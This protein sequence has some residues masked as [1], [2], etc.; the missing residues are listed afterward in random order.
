MKQTKFSLHL[1]INIRNIL[2]VGVHY[3]AKKT[4]FLSEKKSFITKIKIDDG[5]IEIQ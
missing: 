2:A 1:V 3:Y 4:A 5:A